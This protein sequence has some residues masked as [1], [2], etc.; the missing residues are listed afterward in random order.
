MVIVLLCREISRL[1][2]AY[3]QTECNAAAFPGF[4]EDL[5][6]KLEEEFLPQDVIDKILQPLNEIASNQ[7]TSSTTFPYLAS[8]AVRNL[9]EYAD[10]MTSNAN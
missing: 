7:H 8:I 5:T 10:K 6:K 9:Q 3:M 4:K 1:G 2:E